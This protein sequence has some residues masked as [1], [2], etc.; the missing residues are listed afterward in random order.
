[1]ENAKWCDFEQVRLW[2][3]DECKPSYKVKNNM[4]QYIGDIIYQWDRRQ[5]AFEP[6]LLSHAQMFN[7]RIMI[8]PNDL[9]SVLMFI[10]DLNSK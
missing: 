9:E 7:R 10:K 6:L 5:Y 2:G 3:D 4:L 1:M 8:Y